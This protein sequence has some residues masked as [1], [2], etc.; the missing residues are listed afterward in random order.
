MGGGG[1][2]VTSGLYLQAE[3][4]LHG[5]NSRRMFHVV[6]RIHHHQHLFPEIAPQLIEIS[7][8]DCLPGYKCP[9]PPDI[10]I[11]R[12]PY[13]QDAAEKSFGKIRNG[14]WA[15]CI[16]VCATGISKHIGRAISHSSSVVRKKMSDMTSGV[17]YRIVADLRQI[18]LGNGEEEFYPADVVKLSDIIARAIK[19]QRQFP[20]IPVLMGRRDISSDFR[21]I[22]H[23]PD[24]IHIFTNDIPGDAF[25]R[26]SDL[27]FRTFS[28]AFCLVSQPCVFLIAY[29]RNRRSS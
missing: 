1:L 2:V 4:E 22:W 21:R 8:S 29:C 28:D 12:Y 3:R 17:D 24:L 13:V 7:S 10:R 27:F 23:L 11:S 18:N 25:G 20:I 26:T 6:G 15:G 5:M 9:Y 16:V 19:L 14:A